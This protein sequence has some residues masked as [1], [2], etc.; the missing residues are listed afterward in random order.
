MDI[1]KEDPRLEELDQVLKRL[2]QLSLYQGVMVSN[3]VGVELLGR[4]LSDGWVHSVLDSEHGL[5][6]ATLE[7]PFKQRSAEVCL[8]RVITEGSRRQLV[9]VTYKDNSGRP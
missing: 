8:S 1:K 3:L 2:T 6:V 9:L 7:K 4:P 5:L